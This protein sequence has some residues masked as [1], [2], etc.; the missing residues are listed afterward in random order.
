MSWLRRAFGRRPKHPTFTITVLPENLFK[1][2]AEWP[3]TDGMRQADALEMARNTIMALGILTGGSPQ[4]AACFQRALGASARLSSDQVFAELVIEGLAG[5][6]HSTPVYADPVEDQ[7][8]SP[9]DVL[10]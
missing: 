2:D 1:V 8:M 10:K 4:A 3:D 5:G 6:V 9:L 7:A